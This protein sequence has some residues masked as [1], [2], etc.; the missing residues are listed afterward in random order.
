MKYMMDEFT[1]KDEGTYYEL[2]FLGEKL[3]NINLEDSEE[4]V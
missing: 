4:L 3:L 2:V 1:I